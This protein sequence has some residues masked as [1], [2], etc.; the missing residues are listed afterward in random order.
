[1]ILFRKVTETEQFFLLY[2][3]LRFHESYK[4]YK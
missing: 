1:M 3:N 4:D 2:F